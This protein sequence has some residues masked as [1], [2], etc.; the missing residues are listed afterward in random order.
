MSGE[1]S[2]CTANKQDSE[3]NVKNTKIFDK[4]TQNDV[5]K[6]EILEDEQKEGN[7]KDAKTP[8][9]SDQTKIVRIQPPSVYVNQK[10][11]MDVKESDTIFAWNNISNLEIK[12]DGIYIDDTKMGQCSDENSGALIIANTIRS[13]VCQPNTQSF[14]MT[15]DGDNYSFNNCT[16]ASVGRGQTV[17]IRNNNIGGITINGSMVIGNGI[18]NMNGINNSKNI[19]PQIKVLVLGDVKESVTTSSGN[20]NVQGFVQNDVNTSSGDVDI[21]GD[22]LNGK[23][24]T[25]SG[26]VTIQGNVNGGANTMSGDIK[27]GGKL[28]G[29]TNTMSG[30]ISRVDNVDQD[31]NNDDQKDEYPKGVK[32]KGGKRKYY[33]R[34]DEQKRKRTKYQ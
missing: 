9:S 16:I 21:G 3:E 34:N 4:K 25:A 11:V 12:S 17:F 5:K 14:S 32:I 24:N 26:D 2:K 22:I 33:G 23:V 30:K 31:D 15:M 8:Q 10:K 6:I 13:V 1:Q 19:S 20:V 7:D 18:T 28:N 27:I 29:H